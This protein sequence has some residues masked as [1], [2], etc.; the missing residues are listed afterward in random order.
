MTSDKSVK[1]SPPL[2]L[3]PNFFLPPNVIDMRYVNT[4]EDSDSGLVRTE[5]GEVTSVTYDEVDSTDFQEDS[6]STDGDSEESTL[7]TPDSLTLVSQEVR[8]TADGKFVVDVVLE[9]ADV[10]GAAN[11]EVRVTKV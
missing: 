8:V 5:S 6:E 2:E 11:Y 7:P 1:H 10:S 3:D 4:E 9:V